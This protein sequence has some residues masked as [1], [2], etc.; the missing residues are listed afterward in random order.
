MHSKVIIA[1]LV[2]GLSIGFAA[3]GG[4]SISTSKP[5]EDEAAFKLQK[6]ETNSTAKTA[7]RVPVI[8]DGGGGGGTHTHV[9]NYSYDYRNDAFHYANCACGLA[10]ESQEH[11]F[12]SFYPNG[13]GHND[14]IHCSLCNSNIWMTAMQLDNVYND[15]F[16]SYDGTWYYFCP[17]SSGTYI[18]ETTGSTDTYG[19]LYL[20]NFPTTR[21][22]YN[23]DGGVNRNFKITRYLNANQNVFLRVRGYAWGAANYSIS[24]TELHTHNYS[25]I[26]Q[27]D[28]TYHR[29]IC[30]CGESR[31]VVHNYNIPFTNNHS[32]HT[33]ECACGRRVVEAH[34]FDDYLPYGHGHNDLI[35]CARCQANVEC[36]R[37]QEY[38]V[39]NHSIAYEDANWYL[40][41]PETS[42]TYIFETTGNYDTYGDLFVGT[43]PTSITH[44]NDDDGNGNNFRLSY[45]LEAGVNAF[46]RV[47]EYDWEN[48]SYSLTV[49]RELPAPQPNPMAEWTIMM[50]MCGSTLTS[51]EAS[52]IYDMIN[53][54]NQP[55]DVNVIIET[56]GS[57]DTWY[58]EDA[59]GNYIPN[60]QIARYHIRN[61]ELIREA[62]FNTLTDDNMGDEATFESFLNWGLTY[63][64][65]QNVGVVIVNHGR[66]LVGVCNDDRHNDDLLINSEAYTA[67]SNAFDANDIEGKLEFIGYDACMMQLQDVAEF[68]S[69][70]FNYMLA[71][72]IPTSELGWNYIPLLETIYN[73]NAIE[74][75]SYLY[76]DGVTLTALKETAKGFIT[77]GYRWEQTLSILD[78]SQMASYLTA[79]EQLADSIIYR[80][81]NGALST[82]P[83]QNGV[84]MTQDIYGERAYGNGDVINMLYQLE[85]CTDSGLLTK[86]NAVRAFFPNNGD[87]TPYYFNTTIN[88]YEGCTIIEGNGLVKYFAAS[89]GYSG[90]SP[91]THG[92]AV[93]VGISPDKLDDRYPASE[94][95]FNRWRD[96]VLADQDPHIHSFTNTAP[97]DNT[98]HKRVC[99]CGQA[100]YLQRHSFDYTR[101]INGHEYAHCSVC[102]VLI[103]ISN[104]PTPTPVF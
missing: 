1:S 35:H 10:T 91:A 74:N 36:Y 46:L 45:Y 104:T 64:P 88:G 89:K 95:N 55:N 81:A 3:T 48:A 78:L 60:N 56:G 30:S 70:F 44:S 73:H 66:G 9:F 33:M 2:F 41:I 4:R 83:I 84:L 20:G 43:Y 93:C 39:Y 15:S 25:Q 76:P 34:T 62:D 26:V 97:Y 14:M 61:N 23:D 72:Q 67:F 98:Y 16:G 28:A 31:L 18:F 54:P 29:E 24:V 101:F 96:V 102:N 13:H 11:V 85:Q 22:T 63:Y 90:T 49:T 37:M 52:S 42:G 6:Q 100:Y 50:Y 80:I 82:F 17:V 40:F 32:A 59:T 65:A 75:N 57:P 12:D 68:N 79:F 71:S 87:Y 19:E 21:T 77:N 27:Y 38:S 69:H 58:V 94:T 53:V 47:R 8:Q 103:D 51:F 86:I 5:K 7:A 99:E 92:L